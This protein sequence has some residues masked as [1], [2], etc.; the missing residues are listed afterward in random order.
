MMRRLE[1]WAL[2]CG[3]R[4]ALGE[5]RRKWTSP[6]GVRGGGD[7][8]AQRPW[9]QRMGRDHWV[10]PLG[11]SGHWGGSRVRQGPA[12]TSPALSRKQ[13]RSRQPR[14]GPP[15]YLCCFLGRQSQ[16]SSAEGLGQRDM[17]DP[18]HWRDLGG[19]APSVPRSCRNGERVGVGAGVL[20]TPSQPGFWN[21]VSEA[22]VPPSPLPS[23]PVRDPGVLAQLSQDTLRRTTLAVVTSAPGK[24][25]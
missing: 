6:R 1:G 20:L 21:P 18:R 24:V 16:S 11:G 23:D 2:P 14:R 15:S 9:G 5:R 12:E 7:S 13:P 3:C 8:W 25:T 17:V 22:L 19:P 10:H 4:P